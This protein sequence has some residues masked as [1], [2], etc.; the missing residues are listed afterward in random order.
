LRALLLRH[1]GATE[2]GPR[3]EFW[4]GARFWP[5]GASLFTTARIVQRHQMLTGIVDGLPV[6]QRDT[7]GRQWWDRTCVPFADN[8]AGDAWIIGGPRPG[9][10]GR[11]LDDEGCDFGRWPSLAAMVDDMLSAMTG[12][13]DLATGETPQVVDGRL[14]W[15]LL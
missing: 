8:V 3:G 11:H 10:V 7:W 13:Q 12:G 14:E 1:D 5:Y 2:T 15:E 4:E 9:A 6:E